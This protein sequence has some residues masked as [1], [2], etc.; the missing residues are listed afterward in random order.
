MVCCRRPWGFSARRRKSRARTSGPK[1]R[2]TD[3]SQC[4]SPSSPPSHHGALGS[5]A[6]VYLESEARSEVRAVLA[7]LPGVEAVLDRGAAAIALE[8]PEDR[9]GDLVICA[10]A[11]TVLGK[12]AADHDLSAL[13]SEL[14]SHGGLRESEI[15]LVLC[16]PLVGA[17]VPARGLRNADLFPCCSAR[18]PLA[19]LSGRQ[20]QT[21]P[22]ALS[23]PPDCDGPRR[24]SLK[25]T[26]RPYRSCIPSR[27]PQACSGHPPPPQRRSPSGEPRGSGRERGRGTEAGH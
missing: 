20:S 4:P 14:R 2:A 11:K 9:I 15:P 5:L 7:G 3:S 26:I 23:A 22:N 18:I 17:A 24:R 8:L 21:I 1:P 16:Q 12:T 27:L 6:F 13:H 25:R 19:G 10:D